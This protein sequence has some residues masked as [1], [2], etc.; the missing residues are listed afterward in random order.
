[1]SNTP[2]PPP[3][4]PKVGIT[5]V[6]MI[7]DPTTGAGTCTAS[8]QTGNAAQ[9]MPVGPVVLQPWAIA[10]AQR[11]VP[12]AAALLLTR[13]QAQNGE[14]LPA[15]VATIAMLAESWQVLPQPTAATEP[16][17]GLDVLI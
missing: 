17:P 7:L 1:M 4:P 14:A 3:P 5:G 12:A 6:Q 9:S 13:L 16:I 11:Q 10:E 8:L 2:T 15:D